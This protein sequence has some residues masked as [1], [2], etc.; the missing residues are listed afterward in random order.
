MH[1]PPMMRK[2]ADGP[3]CCANMLALRMLYSKLLHPSTQQQICCPAC[4]AD[5]V[6]LLSMMK[7]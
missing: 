5:V 2:R 4:P 3:I 1:F 7:Q 6:S